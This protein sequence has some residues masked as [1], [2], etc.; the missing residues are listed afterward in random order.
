MST[1][2]H[3][4][5]QVEGVFNIR[6]AGNFRVDLERSVKPFLIFRSGE[7]SKITEQG[8]QQLI[9]LKIKTVFDFRSKLEVAA[10]KSATPAI[11]GITFINVPMSQDRFFDPVTMAL[12]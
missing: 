12:R 9:A 11:E 8:I 5:V 6:T 2:V 7:L 3:P 4:F 1:A 10:F